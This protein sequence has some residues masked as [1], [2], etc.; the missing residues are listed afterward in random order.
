MHLDRQRWDQ[1]TRVA[2]RRSA[3]KAQKP[4]NSRNLEEEEEEL[5]E[6]LQKQQEELS[7]TSRQ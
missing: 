1:K 2:A 5:Q 6:L 4:I 7:Q 3:S